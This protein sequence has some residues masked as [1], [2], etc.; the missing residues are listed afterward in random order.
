M[1]TDYIPRHGLQRLMQKSGS[2]RM[3]SDVLFILHELAFNSPIRRRIMLDTEYDCVIRFV[4]TV[5]AEKTGISE[6][7]YMRL[8]QLTDTMHECP[9]PLFQP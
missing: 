7:A 8:R 2:D 6:R 9:D 4:E 1:P 5:L 3:Y